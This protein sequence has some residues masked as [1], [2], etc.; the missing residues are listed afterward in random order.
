MS[1]DVFG[2]V[3][4]DP[5]ELFIAYSGG[6]EGSVRDPNHL[7]EFLAENPRPL[8]GAASTTMGDDG[9]ITSLEG[10]GEAAISLLYHSLEKFDPGCWVEER[11]T[12]G[13]C[14][15]HAVRR[16]VDGTRAVEIDILGEAESFLARGATEPIYGCRGHRGQGMSCSRA[17]KFVSKDGGFLLRKNYPNIDIDLSVYDATVG[18]NWG[19][20]GVPSDVVDKADDH[21]IKT[22]S[23]IT[24]VR[25][26]YD[27]I[28]NGYALACCSSQ[29]FSN[30]R[31]REGFAKPKGSWSHGMAVTGADNVFHRKGFLINNSWGRWNS[32]PKRHN[33]PDGSFWVDEDVF[34]DMIGRR[35]TWVFSSFEGFPPKDL[36]QYLQGVF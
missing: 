7:A 33:Q 25:E 6:F 21:Q 11:Q 8:F 24:S 9:V 12:T 36:P 20:R 15:S 5:N 34:A 35:G 19:S 16:A 30:V 26:A 17:A 27:A 2:N 10:S 4:S 31:D 22:A 3:D 18:T 32:G 13:D 29:G 23:L 14:V 1:D 28:K